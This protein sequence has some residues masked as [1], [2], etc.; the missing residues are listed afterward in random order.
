MDTIKK[1]VYKIEQQKT[2][3]KDSNSM[4]TRQNQGFITN[5]F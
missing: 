3:Q 5:G 4:A 2:D 1:S